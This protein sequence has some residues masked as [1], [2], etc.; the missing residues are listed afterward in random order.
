MSRVVQFVLAGLCVG[1][2]LIVMAENVRLTRQINFSSAAVPTRTPTLIEREGPAPDTEANVSAILE[3]PLF[4]PGRHPPRIVFFAPSVETPEDA[5][6]QLPRL[7]GMT[8]RPGVREALFM[9]EGQKP[10]AVN[11]GG[12]IDGWR[13]SAIELDRVILL[14]TFGSQTIKP[15]ND[16]NAILPRA[17][18]SQMGIGV[19]PS[20]VPSEPKGG[21]LAKRTAG[22][23]L[24]MMPNPGLDSLSIAAPAG[25]Q[26]PRS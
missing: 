4:T 24:P 9:R 17:R 15:T 19:G 16:P 18:P 1:L 2:S 10:M 5:P 23:P 7:A 11:V 8:I 21:N 14:S 22:S 25:R 3:R 20:S 12:E 26:G 13:I 6:G